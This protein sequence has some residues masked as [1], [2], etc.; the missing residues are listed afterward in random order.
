M[1]RYIFVDTLKKVKNELAD[2]NQL[3]ISYLSEVNEKEK[4]K[5]SLKKILDEQLKEVDTTR[6]KIGSQE[7]EK[8]NLLSKLEKLNVR[9]KEIEEII[10][11][12]QIL[13]PIVVHDEKNK[14][15]MNVANGL[16]SVNRDILMKL[17]QIAED[18]G[19]VKNVFTI[20]ILTERFIV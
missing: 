19:K 5:K 7:S 12:A 15:T 16:V 4:I 10:E 3:I 14:D 18:E 11:D 17:I 6:K 1:V 2:S 9:K 13:S 20:V 8:K